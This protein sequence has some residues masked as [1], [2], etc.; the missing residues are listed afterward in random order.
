MRDQEPPAY[1]SGR[2]RS[3]ACLFERPSTWTRVSFETAAYRLGLLPIMLRA[4]EL[5]LGH[6]EPI[7]DTASLS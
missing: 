3:V 4:E 6:G 1:R 7:E 5:Q 2:G